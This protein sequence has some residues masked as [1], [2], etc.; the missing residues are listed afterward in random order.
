MN[1]LC[2]AQKFKTWD[3]N[4]NNNDPTIENPKVKW[5]IDDSIPINNKMQCINIHNAPIIGKYFIQ[6]INNLYNIN[7][8]F[9]IL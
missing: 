3:A 1:N 4:N 7:E 9:G 5:N 6:L 8:W 2:N